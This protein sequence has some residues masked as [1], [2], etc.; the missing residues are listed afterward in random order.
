[1]RQHESHYNS[2]PEIYCYFTVNTIFFQDIFDFSKKAKKS[3]AAR[4]LNIIR[5]LTMNTKDVIRTH[6]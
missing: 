2:Q 3:S 5:L 1:M 6:R 4:L